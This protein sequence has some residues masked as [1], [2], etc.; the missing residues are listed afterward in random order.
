MLWEG[1]A[2]RAANSPDSPKCGPLPRQ[3]HAPVRERGAAAREAAAGC[4]AHV[5][6]HEVLLC[7]CA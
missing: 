1:A 6:T 3:M 2:G 5:S 7:F 4:R